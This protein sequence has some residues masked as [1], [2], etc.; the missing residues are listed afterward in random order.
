ML[1]PM[2]QPIDYCVRMQHEIINQST[3][4]EGDSTQVKQHGAWFANKKSCAEGVPTKSL[5]MQDYFY[6]EGRGTKEA[7]LQHFPENFQSVLKQ[8]SVMSAEKDIMPAPNLDAYVFVRM[9]ADRGQVA[10][11]PS[12]CAPAGELRAL[13][14][15]EQRNLPVAEGKGISRITWGRVCLGGDLPM[16]LGM[17][18]S[19]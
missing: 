19:P 5:H 18:I 8:H 13:G 12:G 17:L 6:E 9:L 1:G 3:P 15:Q 11:D 14:G 2:Q 16:L 10:M 7:V 4:A